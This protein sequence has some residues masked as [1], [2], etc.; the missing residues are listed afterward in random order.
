MKVYFIGSNYDGCYYVRCLLPQRENGWDGQIKTFLI[1]AESPELMFQKAMEADVIVF[2][3]PDQR[4]KVEAIKLLKEAGKKIVVDNDDTYVSDSGADVPTFGR[5]KE[6]LEA[7]QKNLTE[8]IQI[9]DL[10]TASTEV[11]AEEYKK[12]NP[13]VVTLKNCIDP[14]DWTEPKRNEGEKIRV[15]MVGSVTTADYYEIT[16]LLKFLSDSPNH[17]LVILGLPPKGD[18][19]K[20]LQEVM[21]KHIDFWESLNVEWHPLCNVSEYKYVLNELR[22]DLALIPRTKNYFNMCKSNLKF[23]EHSMCEVPCV[24]S[25]FKDSPYENDPVIKCKTEEDWMRAINLPKEELRK[26]GK[27]A[28]QHVLMEYN[29]QDK[30]ELWE[31]AY[32]NIINN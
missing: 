29:I 20:V 17:E 31:Q 4:V 27:T 32:Q 3:R 22:L 1:P 14:E 18:D 23:L 9:A 2:H 26:L 16:T 13:N 7:I 10:V 24:V 15:G 30:A 19:T 5:K 28:K 8:A 25:T 6:I 12:L 11:L 21:K